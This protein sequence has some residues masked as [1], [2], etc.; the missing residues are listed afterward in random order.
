MNTKALLMGF[1]LTA[2]LSAASPASSQQAPPPSEKAKQTEALV[3]KA[4]AL[5]EWQ[6]SLRRVQKERQRVVS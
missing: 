2:S 6:G 3:N 5:I 1:I 4:A